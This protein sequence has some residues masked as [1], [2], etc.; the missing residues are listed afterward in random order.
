MKSWIRLTAAASVLLGVFS[1]PV[2]AQEETGGWTRVH[3]VSHVV[4]RLEGRP[5]FVNGTATAP[6][7]APEGNAM[8]RLY[9]P[10]SGE[11]FYTQDRNERDYL[12]QVG[13][14]LEGLGWYAPNVSG[15]PV[16]RLYNPNAGDHFYT[17]A[18]RE[19]D[20]LVS[21]GWI[22]EGT[23]WYSADALNGTPLYRSYN[24]NAQTGSHNYTQDAREYEFLAGQGWKSEDIGWY[25]IST[26]I[27]T[28]GYAKAL[29]QSM[30]EYQAALS[31]AAKK[32]SL[33]G[34][35]EKADTLAALMRS[36][37]AMS[38][39]RTLAFQNGR[40]VGWSDP[41]QSL[42]VLS[43]WEANR[44]IL[45]C[46]PWK[47]QLMLADT[48]SGGTLSANGCF[49]STKAGTDQFATAC[50]TLRNGRFNGNAVRFER[51]DTG[52]LYQDE[53]SSGE[54]IDNVMNGIVQFSTENVQPKD[55]QPNT[56]NWK[57]SVDHGTAKTELK[58]DLYL[59]SIPDPFGYQIYYDFQPHNLKYWY[60]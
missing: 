9:N 51:Y 4:D 29:E 56:Y 30:T 43:A 21:M 48:V 55:G 60:E 3:R 36:A 15:T 33:D 34:L 18:A 39:G 52:Y 23:G 28:Q 1:V 24:P 6:L 16:Y 40:L 50:G 26:V 35:Y 10:N 38:D 54:A 17:A 27:P 8:Y 47:R 14:T 19:K 32:R 45:I 37:D 44:P 13:W 49:L 2:M 59:V 11:H 7:S 25:G 22:D 12:V 31:D 46:S 53:L 20:H 58:N 42:I 5:T 57:M 41:G